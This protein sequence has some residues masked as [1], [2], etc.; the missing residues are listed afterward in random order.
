MDGGAWQ[1]IMH[2]VTES[3]MTKWLTQ[4]FLYWISVVWN[5]FTHWAPEVPYRDPRLPS[6]L[7]YPQ[8]LCSQRIKQQIICFSGKGKVK[9]NVGKLHKNFFAPIQKAFPLFWALTSWVETP[10]HALTFG[11][12]SSQGLTPPTSARKTCV[13]PRPASDRLLPSCCFLHCK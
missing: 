5:P 10:C 2:G 1:A 3:D 7:L 4:N 13:T 9:N 11:T 6:P 8:D 12:Q